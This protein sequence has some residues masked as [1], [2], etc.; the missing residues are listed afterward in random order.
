M[1]ESNF[2]KVS[3]A[4]KPDDNIVSVHGYSTPL[5]FDILKNYGEK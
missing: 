2:T 3:T 4:L 5:D 1:S